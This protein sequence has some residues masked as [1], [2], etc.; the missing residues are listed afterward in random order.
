MTEQTL[1]NADRIWINANLITLEGDEPYGVLTN[2]V[3]ASKSGKI[4]YIGKSSDLH[5]SDLENSSAEIIDL[6]GKWMSPGLIDCHTHIVFGGNRSKEFE[7]RLTGVSY[8]EIAKQGGGILSTVKAT[9]EASHQELE[10]SAL[11]R[12]EQ[13][14]SEGVTSIEI[15][16]GYGLDTA[17]EL[18]MLEVANALGE[19]LPIDVY[20]TFLGAHALPPEFKGNPDGYID[21]IC[22]GMLPQVKANNLAV[23]VDA[24]CENIGFSREQTQRVFDKA[25]SLGLPVKLH[26]EQLSDQQGTQ[27]AAEYNALSVDHLEYVSEDGVKAIANSGTVAVLLPGAF[28]Y[29][30]ETKLPPIELFR[31]H[32]VPMAIATDCNPGSS[33]C[34]S[35]IL[36]LN[37]ACTLFKMTP[38]EALKGVTLHAAKALGIESIAG[39]LAIGKQADFAIWDISAPADLAYAF[40]HNPCVGVIKNGDVI[41][42]KLS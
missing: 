38:E 11:S 24:F 8:E 12:I 29:L 9:R 21:L 36:M 26:A 13:L 27:L 19:K 5:K 41:L 28:Y 18:K 42:D 3:I 35:L 10:L 4:S 16:S 39:S 37:M 2:A 22:D 23:C 6:A 1:S 30:R 7:L 20:P 33:P 17:S 14:M 34:T 31:Q 32:Q 40:G 25:K 15:K